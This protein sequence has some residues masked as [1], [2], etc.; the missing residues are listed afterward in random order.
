MISDWGQLRVPQL[1]EKV[2]EHALALLVLGAVEQHGAH[3]PLA[4]D[5]IIGEGLRDHL[6]KRLEGQIDV[7]VLPSLAVGASQE[8][9]NFR[10]TLSLPPSTAIDVL[11]ALGESVARAGIRRLMLLNSHGGN[12]AVMDVAALNLRRRFGLLVV[13]ASYTRLPPPDGL[14]GADELRDGLHGGQAETSMM[15]HLA[16]E[17]VA[18][19]QAGNVSLSRAGRCA[20]RGLLGPSGPASWAWM[21]EDLH[22]GGVVGRAGDATVEIGR[23][24][25][26]HYAEGLAEIAVEAAT[27]PWAGDQD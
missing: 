22:A 2:H 21:A 13:K 15:L 12:H 24:L 11:E 8:H 20:E 10:G 7:L 23:Q 4:T 18:L 16:P 6:L 14:L 19:D 3:L 27:M 1:E 25:I 5:L 26:A 17:T 9:L